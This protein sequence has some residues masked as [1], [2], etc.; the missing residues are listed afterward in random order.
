M[1]K[2][3]LNCT[4]WPSTDPFRL[5]PSV[6]LG[7]LLAAA[8][9]RADTF[10]YRSAEG[11]PVELEAKLV[12]SDQ[13][14]YI[15]ETSDG[16]YHLVPRG[17]A[18]KRVPSPGPVA[19]DGPGM[20]ARLEQEF[21]A[22]RFRSYLQDP[23]VIGL[24]LGSPLPRT[25]EGAAK[26]LLRDVAVFMKNVE[27]AFARYA[28]DARVETPAA[29]HPVVVLI[30]ET[31]EDFGK[32]AAAATARDED[33]AS[34]IA[35]FYSKLTNILAI[36]LEEC[37]SFDT[38]LH[39]A[40]HQQVYVRKI[41]PRLAPIPTWFDE[42]LATGFE[43]NAGKINVGP[44]KISARYANQAL[45]AQ[46]VDW[47]AL[48]AGDEAFRND[49]TIDGAYGQ[50]WGLHWLLVTR[51]K[52]EYGSYMRL[53]GK[54][55][56]LQED[57]PQQRLA[58]FQQAFGD[59]LAE[60]QSQFRP[61]LE[62][63][64]RKQKIVLKPP[65]RK[66]MSLTEENLG[67]VQLTAVSHQTAGPVGGR[68]EVQGALMNLSPLRTMAFHVTVETDAA[69]YAEW[70]IPKLDLLKTTPLAAQNVV[71]PMRIAAAP[72]RGPGPRTFR[73]RIRSAPADS[74][75]AQRWS[76]GQLPVPVFGAARP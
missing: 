66:G 30:F 2:F 65:A 72:G 74:D 28:R 33:F 48:V 15:L 19:L 35:G 75:E 21:T 29:T 53:L 10:H 3:S 55:K 4:T 73:V 7:L 16:R 26:A 47:S 1:Q 46:Q 6:I 40:I 43:G 9:C 22:E 14:I 32:F 25:S 18:E 34:R 60:M 56:P 17:A 31:R 54:K 69:T 12:G 38:P 37:R 57:S 51:Y 70:L 45:E 13:G 44:G 67:Q 68:L 71:K 8:A 5:L 59:R 58:D 52:A 49:A 24:V 50:A 39:E 42:G 41:L 62:D 27:G 76:S 61:L 63:A 11:Q 64:C 23:F 20:A 36:R